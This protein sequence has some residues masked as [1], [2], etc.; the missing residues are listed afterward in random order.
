MRRKSLRGD[1]ET[2][3]RKSD[4]IV[5]E[6]LN[7]R[8]EQGVGTSDI[9]MLSFTATILPDK[10]PSGGNSAWLGVVR[11]VYEGVY[12]ALRVSVRVA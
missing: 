1:Q 6:P 9:H 10:R 2:P 11:E 12:T 3:V 7:I 5:S 4:G 8:D